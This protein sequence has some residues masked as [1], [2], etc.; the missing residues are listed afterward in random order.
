MNVVVTSVSTT[1]EQLRTE[2][3]YL[4]NL[5][6]DLKTQASID[7]TSDS[8]YSMLYNEYEAKL[9][10]VERDI[11]HRE[12]HQDREHV[13]PQQHTTDTSQP[14]QNPHI[15]K[16]ETTHTHVRKSVIPRAKSI[17]VIQPQ[18]SNDS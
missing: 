18:K 6:K 16:I 7:I 3:N 1:L 15:I 2:R 17:R 8:T 5:L 12:L 13:V 4:L 10:R 14:T 11:S 9:I